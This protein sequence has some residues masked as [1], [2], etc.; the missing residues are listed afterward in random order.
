[1]GFL[2]FLGD[3]SE[4]D[5]DRRRRREKREEKKAAK[6]Q[7]TTQANAYNILGWFAFF[8]IFALVGLLSLGITGILPMTPGPIISM[9]IIL[10]LLIG[11]I[12]EMQWIK[13][14]KEPKRKVVAIVFMVAIGV[15]VALW[16]VSVAMLYFVLK[17]KAGLE[18]GMNYVVPVMQ[19]SIVVS[20]QLVVASL[21]AN[22]VL[23]YG[24]NLLIIQIVAYISH[25]FVDFYLSFLVCCVTVTGGFNEKLFGFLAHPTMIAIGVLALL[26]A[27]LSRSILKKLSSGKETKMVLGD[28]GK[29]KEVP[30]IEEKPAPAAAPTAT[31]EEKKTVKAR[32]AELKSLLDD[33][34]ITQEEYDQKKA[35]IISKM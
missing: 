33:G 11:S 7:G 10:I 32:L 14:L 22:T 35:D 31:A 2:K 1:M 27:L 19:A 16:V 15:C 6:A 9:A 3:L 4:I 20:L 12:L 21:I 28:D 30:V 24:K 29:F 18:A 13:Y 5:A 8:G 23:K 26:Y 25:A 17:S 34:I